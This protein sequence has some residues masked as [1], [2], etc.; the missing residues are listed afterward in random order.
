MGIDGAKVALGIFT[1]LCM[2]LA[3]YVRLSVKSA[4]MDFLEKL[5][6]TYVRKEVADA[7]KDAERHAAMIEALRIGELEKKTDGRITALEQGRRQTGF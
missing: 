4:L 3:L 6:A 2:G 5:G 1:C 7:V